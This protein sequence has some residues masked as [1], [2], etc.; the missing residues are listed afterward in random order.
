MPFTAAQFFDVF[1]RYNQAV[2]P[3]QVV[4]FVL[5][6]A[7]SIAAVRGD[8]YSRYSSVLLAFLWAWDAL[9][10]HLAFFRAI[11][12][13]AVLFAAMF[14]AQSALFVWYG[15]VRKRISFGARGPWR[16]VGLALI[17]YALVVYPLLGFAFGQRY[18]QMPT[19]GLPC[20]TTIYTLGMLMCAR[21]AA[22]RALWIVPLQ[23][24]LIGTQAAILFGVREDYGLPAAGAVS[25][26]YVVMTLTVEKRR[27]RTA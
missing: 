8:K 24:A 14:A 16:E 7:A 22:P 19:F 15:I 18:P 9:V 4:F 6:A 23:W 21:P 5:A 2:W 26:Y 20:P 3:A 13:A 11:N 12:P 27:A 25:L 1:G 10:Y 17:A